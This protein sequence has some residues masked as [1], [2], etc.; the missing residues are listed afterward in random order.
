MGGINVARRIFEAI[1]PY[2]DDDQQRYHLVRR[3][4]MAG[5]GSP[6][7]PWGY[8]IQLAAK[9][10][11]GRKPYKNKD[12]QWRKLCCLSQAYAAVIDVQPYT[13]TFVGT[14][15]ATDLVPY[16]QEMAVYDTLFC[17]PQIRPTDVVKIIRGILS[18]LDTSVPTKA[19]W[20]VDQVIEIIDYLLKK[21]SNVRGPIFVDG[22]ITENGINRTLR[23]GQLQIAISSRIFS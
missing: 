22:D 3:T 13:R 20:S 2:Y 12:D 6:Q 8:L 14:M 4:S 23:S 9:H 10:A 7:I 18:W 1:S 15:D 11:R 19:G 16:L 21:N 17:I 5:G